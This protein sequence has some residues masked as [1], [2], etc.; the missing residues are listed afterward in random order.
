M[1]QNILKDSVTV[2]SAHELIHSTNSVDAHVQD[3]AV[4]DELL[5]NILEGLAERPGSLHA[6]RNSCLF[7]SVGSSKTVR[8]TY[9]QQSCSTPFKRWGPGDAWP[10]HLNNSQE[11]T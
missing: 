10:H 9:Q 1:N 5:L 3:T 7:Q 6:T 11:T 8:R 2:R 4:S